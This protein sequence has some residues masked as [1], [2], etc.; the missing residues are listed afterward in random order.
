MHGIALDYS[1][2]IPIVQL[3]NE[4]CSE[5]QSPEELIDR[6]EREEEPL[7]FIRDRTPRAVEF[8]RDHA[9]R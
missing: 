2:D 5:V 7:I 3:G 1:E 6:V 8:C 4:I 9:R